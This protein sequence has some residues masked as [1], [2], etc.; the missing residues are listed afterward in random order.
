MQ[1][2]SSFDPI[3]DLT[4]SLATTNDKVHVRIKQRNGKKSTTTIENLP[5]DLNIQL[6]AKKMRQTFHCNGAVQNTDDGNHIMLFGDQ[7]LA[8]K[9]FLT[10][11]KIVDEANISV[12]GY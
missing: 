5:K 8:V 3:L 6:I 2:E 7:R 12:H 10:S 9:N 1:D 11:K 4:N